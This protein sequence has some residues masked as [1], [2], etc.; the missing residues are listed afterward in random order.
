M[1]RSTECAAGL[2]GFHLRKMELA[3]LVAIKP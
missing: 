2:S 3:G 1:T